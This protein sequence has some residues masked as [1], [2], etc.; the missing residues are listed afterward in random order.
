MPLLSGLYVNDNPLEAL[1]FKFL[2]SNGN[3]AILPINTTTY[4]LIKMKSP[5]FI[6]LNTKTFGGFGKNN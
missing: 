2:D 4:V 6:Q 5:N 3:Q 1:A